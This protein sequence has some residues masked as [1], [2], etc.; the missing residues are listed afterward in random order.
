MT[1]SNVI[2]DSLFSITKYKI[3]HQVSSSSQMDCFMMHAV[4]SIYVGGIVFQLLNNT[5][6]F[7]RTVSGMWEI[8]GT[9]NFL[10][11]RVCKIS[12][13]T[14]DLMEFNYSEQNEFCRLQWRS[15]L[16]GR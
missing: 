14:V 16:L 5:T 9:Y 11:F 12:F 2:S 7:G 8:G 3:A 6:L 1:I 10:A 13:H 4:W 15:S